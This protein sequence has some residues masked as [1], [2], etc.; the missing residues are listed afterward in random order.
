MMFLLRWLVI[1]ILLG[2]IAINLFPA[3]IASAVQT[4]V[5]NVGGY[6][7]ELQQLGASASWYETALWYGSAVL[8][9]IALVRL[10]RK[11]Q[12]FWAW[13]LGFACYGGHWALAEQRE[14]GVM[15]TLQSLTLDSIKPENVQPD[16]PV[17]ALGLIVLLFIIGI[18]IWMIDH[19]DRAYWNRQ[20]A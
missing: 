10:V 19:G 8:L 20:L 18:L 1:L 16:S 2:F 9:F 12:A 3:V 15:T 13:L 17:T 4:D 6:S 7:E 14:G 5:I 11:T